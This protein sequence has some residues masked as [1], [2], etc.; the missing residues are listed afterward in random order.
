MLAQAPLTSGATMRT[1][2]T[3]SLLL[4]APPTSLAFEQAFD[5]PAFVVSV[6]R[7]PNLRIA[8]APN[9]SDPISIHAQGQDAVFAVEITAEASAQAGSSRRC[10]S[11]FLQDLVKRPN[12]PDRDSIY[13]APLDAS[14]FLVL[15]I[16]EQQRKKVLHAHLLS[17]AAGT[18]CINAHFSRDAVDGEDEDK[19]RTTFE[20]ARIREGRK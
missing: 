6:P 15:Y 5:A 12:M 8:S 4:L 17:A 13:R 10:A 2:A 20:D 19:W 1:F 14:T 18:H 3:V 11:T 9:S 7:V 16:F